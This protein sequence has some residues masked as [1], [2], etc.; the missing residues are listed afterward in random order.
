MKSIKDLKLTKATE[1][2]VENW[3]KEILGAL[4]IQADG[5]KGNVYRADFDNQDFFYFTECN[6]LVSKEVESKSVESSLDIRKRKRVIMS[7]LLI[8]NLLG[9]KLEKKIKCSHCGYEECT[10]DSTYNGHYTFCPK[11]KKIGLTGYLSTII[12]SAADTLKQLIL[13][14]MQE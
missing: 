7:Q 11:C 6:D 12:E 2:K 13:R 8:R 10:I 5:R 3:L 14:E 4:I 9:E 1:K